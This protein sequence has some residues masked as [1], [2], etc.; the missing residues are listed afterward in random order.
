MLTLRKTDL[1]NHLSRRI[2]RKNDS[3]HTVTTGTHHQP[4]SADG[5]A[6][7]RERPFEPIHFDPAVN[8]KPTAYKSILGL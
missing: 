1:H 4:T 8:I 3:L 5:S 2:S 6:E 7:S